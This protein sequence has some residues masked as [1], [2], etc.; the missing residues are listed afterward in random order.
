MRNGAVAE[1]VLSL[2]VSPERSAAIVG[3]LI[4]GGSGSVSFWIQIARMFVSM[5]WRGMAESPW[6][7]AGLA[8]FGLLT[9]FW[10]AY[11]IALLLAGVTRFSWGIFLNTSALANI[12]L[13]LAIGFL[14]GRSI[15]RRGMCQDFC[16]NDGSEVSFVSRRTSTSRPDD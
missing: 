13:T 16:V 15:A 7:I 10:W 9:G 4:E 6:R 8:L 2:V 14:V 12:L 1:W 11:F 3:D 5:L